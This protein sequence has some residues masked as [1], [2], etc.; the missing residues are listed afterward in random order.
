MLLRHGERQQYFRSNGLTCTQYLRG[1]F[2]GRTVV[3]HFPNGSKCLGPATLPLRHAAIRR[4]RSTGSHVR[5]FAR[6]NSAALG[7]VTLM[8]T[9]GRCD[10]TGISPAWFRW[11]QHLSHCVASR[12][13]L[14]S[15]VARIP[16]PS[17]V[18]SMFRQVFDLA[19]SQLSRSDKLRK[20]QTPGNPSGC[21]HER[22]T[23]SVIVSPRYLT[24]ANWRRMT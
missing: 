8:R 4:V 20:A 24:D 14:P 12:L 10:V 22:N 13:R 19:Q 15:Q 21:E 7:A 3:S 1:V 5:T 17:R 11:R 16:R 9:C 2:R 6:E 18:P 23:Q